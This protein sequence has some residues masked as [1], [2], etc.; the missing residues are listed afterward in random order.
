MNPWGIAFSP[1]SPIWISDN[2]TGLATIYNGAG[3]KQGLV[4]SIPALGGG[5]G[6]P[7]GQFLTHKAQV[8]S[9]QRIS[10]MLWYRVSNGD[11]DGWVRADA[12]EPRHRLPAV[13]FLAGM[14][15]CAATF[16]SSFFAYRT[17]KAGCI[18]Y[19][20]KADRT[21]LGIGKAAELGIPVGKP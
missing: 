15:A 10:Q 5:Q 18:A 16:I 8:I 6:A 4:V 1:T 7:T 14:C 17:L 12:V 19:W 11:A 21:G 2:G 3:V 20:P 13:H 9:I